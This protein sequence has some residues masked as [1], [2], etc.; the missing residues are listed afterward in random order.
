[1]ERLW[2]IQIVRTRMNKLSN[3]WFPSCSRNRLIFGA[4]KTIT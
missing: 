3:T 4:R 1:L 2:R